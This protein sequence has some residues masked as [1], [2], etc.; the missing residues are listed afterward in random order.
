LFVKFETILFSRLYVFL[1]KSY[2][3]TGAS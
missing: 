2:P 1:Q 3:L